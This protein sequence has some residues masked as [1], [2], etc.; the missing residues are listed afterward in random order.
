MIQPKTIEMLKTFRVYSTED[1]L[2]NRVPAKFGYLIEEL[3]GGTFSIPEY[4]SEQVILKTQTMVD[5]IYW[6]DIRSNFRKSSPFLAP[7]NQL[8]YRLRES[9][10]LFAFQK[11]VKPL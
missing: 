5:A 1:L 11:Q 3:V 6:E 9:G 2:Q 10:I 4:T 7:L 8:I